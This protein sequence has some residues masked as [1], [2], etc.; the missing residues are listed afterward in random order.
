MIKEKVTHDQLILYDILRHPVLGP[1]FI[2][3]MDNDPKYDS[4]FEF[5]DYQKEILCDF[6]DHV[7]ICTAR[8]VGKTV[9]LV[10][11][12]LWALI[13]KIFAGDYILYTVP[14]KVHLQPVWDGLLRAFRSNSFLSNF[15]QK[16]SG[17]NSSDFSIRLLNGS[18]LIC[19]IAGQSG[20]GANLVGLHTPFILTDEAGYFPWNAFQEMQPALNTFTRGYREVVSGVPTGMREKN[21]LY[22]T[23]AENEVYSKHRVS[24]YDNPR[25]SEKDIQNFIE[26]YGGAETDDFTHYVLGKHGKPIFALFD[27]SLFRIENYPVYKLNIDGIKLSDS[28]GEMYSKIEAFP[29]LSERHYGI[30][31][32]IDLGYTEP[33]AI[34]IFYIDDKERIRFHGRIK[35]TKVAY[36][37]QERLIDM[38]DT[39]FNPFIIGIDRGNAGVSVIQ[40]LQGNADYQHKNYSERITPIDFSSSVVIGVN[41]DGEENKVKTKV[42]TVSVVQEYSNNHKL[43]YS[44]TD[45]EMIAEL[46]RMTYT[47][48]PSGEV[49]YRT[50]TDR[51][52]YKGEDH[53]TSAL[54]CGVGAYYFTKEYGVSKPRLRLMKS[55]WI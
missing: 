41:A 26:Q 1:E 43:V 20:T 16:N 9:S 50:L 25:I 17:I 3:N 33:T 13:F 18:Q 38:L 21:V 35:L 8:A 5:T 22:H 39:R 30:F 24:A 4:E 45:P 54:L 49:V 23:D 46:E 19:R 27:R 40:S 10:S 29:G 15:V 48:T 55:N 32:G 31:F 7:S 14:S 28:L 52:G 6:N 2:Y 34:S 53:F 44:S 37:I 47:K 36:P 12:I 11:L 42:L 51:G